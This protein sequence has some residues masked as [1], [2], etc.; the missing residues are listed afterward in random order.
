MEDLFYY[1]IG[2]RVTWP[3]A[4]TGPDG[5]TRS[6]VKQGDLFVYIS[7]KFVYAPVTLG[8]FA[9]RMPAV[10]RYFKTSNFCNFGRVYNDRCTCAWRMPGVC[11]AYAQ[12]P[13]SLQ[14]VLYRPHHKY[15]NLFSLLPAISLLIKIQASYL[16]HKLAIYAPRGPE[17]MEVIGIYFKVKKYL[18]CLKWI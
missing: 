6:C 12:R 3:G 18:L 5:H 14:S 11:L 15:I 2:S 1:D 7:P 10:L 13:L 9:Q 8:R 4:E 16:K 17:K